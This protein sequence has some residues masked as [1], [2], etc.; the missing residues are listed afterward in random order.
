MSFLLAG[1]VITV[2]RSTSLSATTV[3]ARLEISS[4]RRPC[5]RVD[6][7]FGRT[8]TPAGV[9]A[10]AARTGCGGIMLR[11]LQA[12]SVCAGDVVQVT[13]RRNPDWSVA[14]VAALLYGHPTACMMYASRHVKLSEWMGSMQE[15][16]Q[17]CAL[18][19]LAHLEWKD[20]VR[21]SINRHCYSCFFSL[22]VQHVE[23]GRARP[24]CC[25]CLRCSCCVYCLAGDS[26]PCAMH[27]PRCDARCR[28][29][30]SLCFV[31]R[32]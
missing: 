27:S 8:F 22:D 20:Q 1:D 11:V 15:L 17:A 9:R 24:C 12:G 4:P 32:S 31:I 30:R 2:E 13:Q 23:R 3:V 25:G 14:R 16:Q 6:Q 28:L 18:E 5:S 7:R 29:I 26:V 21:R 10:Q 19:Q